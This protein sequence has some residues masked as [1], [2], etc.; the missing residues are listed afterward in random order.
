MLFEDTI[1]SII[2][3]LIILGYPFLVLLLFVSPLT[4]IKLRR[5]K[6]TV[7]NVIIGL[8]L[9]TALAAGAIYAAYWGILLLG[10]LAV[11]QLYGGQI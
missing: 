1:I 4:Y 7:L 5:K 9:G 10:G 8:L 2:S 11:Y 6:F 3:W